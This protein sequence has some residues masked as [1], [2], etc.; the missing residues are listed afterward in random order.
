MSCQVV[1]HVESGSRRRTTDAA[2]ASFW[3]VALLIVLID[4]VSKDWARDWV[5]FLA[6]PVTLIPGIISLTCVQNPGLAFGIFSDH[7][8]LASVVAAAAACLIAPWGELA[9]LAQ[10]PP[11]LGASGLALL[12]GGALGNLLDRILLGRVVDFIELR[13]GLVFNFAD[14]AVTFGIVALVAAILTQGLSADRA[15]PFETAV[16]E[17]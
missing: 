15:T 2:T 9:R 11:L 14:V 5:A 6:S 1:S 3:L 7:G 8:A 13:G 10:A 12:L 16:P 4:Q 17:A